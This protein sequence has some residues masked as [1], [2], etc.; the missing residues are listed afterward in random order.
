MILSAAWDWIALSLAPYF[1]AQTLPRDMFIEQ[2][3][4]GRLVTRSPRNNITLSHQ[5]AK[6]E[7]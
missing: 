6:E 4:Q 5:H 2:G 7:E 1:D 3:S